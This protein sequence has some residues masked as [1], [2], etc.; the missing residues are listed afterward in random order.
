MPWQ[1]S[2]VDEHKKG[3]SDK[4]KETW[5][6]VANEALSACEEKGGEDCDASAIRQANAVA[7]KGV[8]ALS[9]AIT[10]ATRMKDGRVRFRG[11]ANSGNK[12]SR[13]ERLDASLFSDFVDN[14]MRVQEAQTRGEAIEGMNPVQLDV[15]HFSFIAKDRSVAR[16][17]WPYRMWVDGRALM[18]QG[19]FDQTPMGQAA[20]KAVLADTHK[21]IRLSVGFYPDWG[22]V[23]ME[24]DVLVYRGGR[25]VAH[26]DHIALTAYPVDAD[27][28]IRVLEA[29][30]SD[31]TLTM[32][33]DALAVL[34]DEELAEGLEAAAKSETVPAGAV[35]KAED[36]TEEEVETEAE[37]AEEAIE[38][39]V[40]VEPVEAGVTEERLEEVVTS[41]FANVKTEIA[42]LGKQIKALST[43]LEALAV[44]EGVKVKAALDS[45]SGD[46][47]GQLLA[48]S[49][50]HKADV[51][52]GGAM[53]SGPEEAQK[54]GIDQGAASALGFE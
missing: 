54:S 41:I 1:I 7:G 10:K 14:F 8:L 28:E 21:K 43:K 34:G 48:N 36:V 44:D 45:P 5:V 17:G 46:W 4:E 22:N 6:K 18:V 49:T 11:R 39:P 9:M 13:E 20:A 38:E 50:Q 33:D 16:A 37:E 40:V 42:G 47:L 12:D 15:A 35:I 52:K 29:T 3:L 27:T 26:L 23:A 31:G 25:G 19:W 51:V 30:M 53:E 32:K 2:D 24:D